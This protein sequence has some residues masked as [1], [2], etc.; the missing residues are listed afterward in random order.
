MEDEVG[1]MIWGG[2]LSGLRGH[3]EFMSVPDDAFICNLRVFLEKFEGISACGWDR[4][5]GPQTLRIAP[6]KGLSDRACGRRSRGCSGQRDH[7]DRWTGLFHIRPEPSR[8]CGTGSRKIPARDAHL[9]IA[10]SW[11]QPS[12][13]RRLPYPYCPELRS[14]RAR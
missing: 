11:P 5:S 10:E 1:A 4:P 8:I 2:A 12:A 7:L 6:V 13:N 3:I 9:E 14:T